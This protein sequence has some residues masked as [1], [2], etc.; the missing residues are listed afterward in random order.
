MKWTKNTKYIGFMDAHHAP[1]TPKHRYWVGLLFFALIIH[2][3]VT[4]FSPNPYL[5]VI[6]AGCLPVGII[7][8]KAMR[9]RVYKK[10]LNDAAETLFLLNLIF[11]AFGT[12]YTN[13]TTVNGTGYA[14][15]NTSV[16]ITF[17]LF[18][19]FVLGYHVY[20]F[21][22]KITGVFQKISRS[23][24]NVARDLKHEWQAHKVDGRETNKSQV[25]V[26][27]LDLPASSECNSYVDGAGKTTR[28]AQ[29]RLSY[30]DD[31][32]PVVE[33]DYIIV[34]STSN[35]E[36]RSEVTITRTVIEF[37]TA[38]EL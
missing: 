7:V 30:I 31:L 4:A 18:V 28:S 12:I 20:K 10:G 2:N 19:V 11:L 1:F 9:I 21:I 16:G 25:M 32:A 29:L 13:I 6:S 15:A 33:G 27:A 17:V 22:L 3:L 36:F 5:P 38:K 37:S 23:V 24:R 8:F 35:S 26:N 14:L 34:P